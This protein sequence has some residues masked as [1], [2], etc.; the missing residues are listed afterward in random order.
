MVALIGVWLATAP[1]LAQESDDE[2]GFQ[3]NVG[4][5][6]D[7]NDNI[8]DSSDDEVESWIGRL[9]PELSVSSA[10]GARQLS[11][12]Y[13]G[14]YGKYLDSSESDD[15]YADHTVTGRGLFQ[16][17]SRG[18]LDLSAVYV[19]AHEPRGSGLSRGLPPDSPQFPPE[20]DEF[21]RIGWTAQYTHGSRG[22]RGRLN[23]GAGGRDLEHTNNRDRTQFFDRDE[24]YAFAGISIGARERTQFVLQARYTETDYD[25]DRPGEPSRSGDNWRAL[26]GVTW[27]ATAKTEGSIG[28]GAQRREFDDAAR[29][30][31]DSSSWDVDI[32]WSPRE[33]S[34]VD[35]VT[36]REIVETI[37]GGDA[38]ERSSY[39]VSWTHEWAAGF[40]SV[41]SW[42]RLDD[43]FVGTI[44][45]EDETEIYLGLRLPQGERVIWEAGVAHR[46][47]NSTLTDLEFEGMLYTIGVNFQLTR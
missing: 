16:S 15:D 36:T 27:E 17:G 24:I 2:G 14:D 22:A 12:E 33:Y 43:D 39:G 20:P 32:R 6:F 5:K 46:E 47:R 18:L 38:I 13:I 41:V 40:E 28:I 21:E 44:R 8:Y 37:A 30:T 1:V 31:R 34:H 26:V 11:L 25:V 45:K 3:A 19:R 10:P 23:F 35:L 42:D 29:D 7:L 9:S 4:V